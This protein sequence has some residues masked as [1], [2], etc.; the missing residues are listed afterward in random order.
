MPAKYFF[1]FLIL[2]VAY[3]G[4]CLAFV[5][6]I[7][8]HCRIQSRYLLAKPWSAYQGFRPLGMSAGAPGNTDAGLLL[9]KALNS[10][11][12]ALKQILDEVRS[13]RETSSQ[14]ML[15]AFLDDI[16]TK[17]DEEQTRTWWTKFRITARFSKRS[18]RASLH[19]L[20]NMSTPSSDADVDI[21]EDQR[22]GRRRSLLVALRSL[23]VEDSESSANIVKIEKEAR[24]EL[25]N[26]FAKDMESRLPPG[27]E[28]PKYDV[29]VKR[30]NF[31][32]RDY[33]E[34]SIC[35]VKMNAP[36]P[37][38][39]KTDRQVSQPQLPGASSFGALAGY[40]FGKNQEQTSMKMTTP[41]FTS[42]EGTEKEMA[43]VLPSS[44][45]GEDSL[46]K[47]PLPLDDSLVELK[48]DCGGQRA[49]IMFGGFSSKKDVE[50]RRTELMATLEDDKD[51][52]VPANADFTLAQ[53]NDPF[54]PPWKRRNEISIPVESNTN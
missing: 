37:N 19:R 39:S 45:W 17:V 43:F 2:L 53:Y 3:S 31:E 22:R 35:S 52:C 38:S 15:E 4:Y 26:T 18:R 10:N 51:W 48:R 44:Y 27:L 49:V 33:S 9:D 41:V 1:C 13:L 16:L 23:V 46:S 34:F 30:R 8:S 36:R 42:G 14:E 28:T 20:L 25:K 47:A 21:E 32:I 11:Q 50:S 6:P 24:R 5:S 7:P 40:L 54:T 12:A 29:V